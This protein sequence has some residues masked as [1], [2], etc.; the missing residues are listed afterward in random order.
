MVKI[1]CECGHA[2]DVHLPKSEPTT[3][4]CVQYRGKDG[5]IKCCKCTCFKPKGNK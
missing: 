1:I 3:E 4:C 2:E 5:L